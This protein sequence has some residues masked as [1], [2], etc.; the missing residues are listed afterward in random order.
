MTIE[1]SVEHNK[2]IRADVVDNGMRKRN[3]YHRALSSTSILA[4]FQ[5]AAFYVNQNY[6]EYQ[7]T[8]VI[9]LIGQDDSPFGY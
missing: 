2:W 4:E 8:K 3:L 6:P 9:S 5:D 1:I 7:N